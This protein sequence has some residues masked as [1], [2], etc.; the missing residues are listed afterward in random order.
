[1]A[2]YEAERVWRKV[3]VERPRASTSGGQSGGRGEEVVV[4]WVVVVVEVE[5]VGGVLLA[6]EVSFFA[7]ASQAETEVQERQLDGWSGSRVFF[8][9]SYCFCKGGWGLTVCRL[10]PALRPWVGLSFPKRLGLRTRAQAS[11]WS[12]GYR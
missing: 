4:G 8:G 11:W 6:A 12:F 2:G 3:Q 9:C 5:V 1:M 7:M 10:Y